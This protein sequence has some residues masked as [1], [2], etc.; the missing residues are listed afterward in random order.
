[1]PAFFHHC[2]S[3]GKLGIIIIMALGIVTFFGLWIQVLEAAVLP[4]GFNVLHVEFAIT[5]EQMDRII[6]LWLSMNV[7]HVEVFIDQLDVLMMPGWSIMFFG[8]QVLGLRALRFLGAGEKFRKTSWKIISLPLIAGAVDT[9]ENFIIFYV[10]SNPSTYVRAIVPILFVFVMAK[11]AMLFTGIVI[12]AVANI[13]AL[14]IVVRRGMPVA[15]V[16][17]ERA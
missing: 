1:V 2:P 11:W 17:R 7:L 10:L 3:D 4:S 12:G 5:P 9:V 15:P 16:I 13:G 14:A 8:V 6:S